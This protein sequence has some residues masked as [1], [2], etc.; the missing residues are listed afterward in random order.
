MKTLLLLST[1]LFCFTYAH[2]KEPAELIVGKWRPVE[3]A[4]AIVTWEFQ[5]DGTLLI[6]ADN[7]KVAALRWKLEEPDI[8]I[9]TGLP[10]IAPPQ[11]IKLEEG[12]LS[13]QDSIG[14]WHEMALIK[15]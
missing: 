2:A 12:K 1:L 3:K 5:K 14:K 11:K 7:G 13:M 4:E 10:N 9:V 15:D 8:L 6:K